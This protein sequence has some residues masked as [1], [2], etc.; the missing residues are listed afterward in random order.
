MS[1]SKNE[2]LIMRKEV[3]LICVDYFSYRETVE[4]VNTILK[5]D[6]HVKIILVCNSGRDEF[7]K[8]FING[9]PRLCIYDF[10]KNLGYMQAAHLGL[11]EYL[12]S[13]PLP[14][15]IILS[16]TDISFHANDF[17][18]TLS[19]DPRTGSI[20]A[21]DIIS[22]DGYHQNPFL[23]YRPSGKKLRFLRLIYSSP[24]I[25]KLYSF[26]ANIKAKLLKSKNVKI[27]KKPIYAPHGSFVIIGS[28][29]FQAGCT[30]EHP[31]FLY[32]EELFIAE[33]ARENNIPVMFEPA[34]KI[35]HAEHVV[36][37]KLGGKSKAGY[38]K[39]S[40]TYFFNKYYK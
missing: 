26:A 7:P 39:E 13:N 4:Y 33:R 15:W 6:S 30:L 14:D 12:K 20:L 23:S 32:G 8:D 21:P 36:T 16:N 27:T 40:I 9:G 22:S 1:F 24:F 31:T 28:G 11:L 19:H 29:Y 18:E 17:F 34:Y 37:G 2:N 35:Y 3:L 38:L 25:F 10:G 5:T